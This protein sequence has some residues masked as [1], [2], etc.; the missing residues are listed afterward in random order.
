MSRADVIA[1]IERAL[2]DEAYR[3]LLFTDPD[4]AL[5]GYSLTA[6]ETERLS[7]LDAD[8]FDEFAGPLTGRTTKGQW[9]PGG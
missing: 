8:N 1:I 7:N 2:D 3:N 5:Q 4:Q 6:D 9:I